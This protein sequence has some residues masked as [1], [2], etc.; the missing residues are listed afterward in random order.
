MIIDS[1]A[2]IAILLYEPEA[3]HFTAAIEND[4][5]RLMSAA[6]L[7][8]SSIVIE[9]RYGMEGERKLDLL[10]DLSL[11]KRKPLKILNIKTI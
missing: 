3:E 4:P 1:S 5:V 10:L 6:S 7:L 9:S 2:I 11:N 8:E